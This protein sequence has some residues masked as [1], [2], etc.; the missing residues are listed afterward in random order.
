MSSKI[1][2]SMVSQPEVGVDTAI[3]EVEV[4]IVE[5]GLW[6]AVGVDAAIVEEEAGG[7]SA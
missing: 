1:S 2:S 4:G 3:E 7:S 5:V 6:V